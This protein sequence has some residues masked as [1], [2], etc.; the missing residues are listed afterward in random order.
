MDEHFIMANGDT[1]AAWTRIGE[2]EREFIRKEIRRCLNDP[3]YYLENYHIIRT[4]QEGLKTL[5]P[6]WDSQELF[7]EMVMKIRIAGKQCKIMILKARQLGL[8]TIC[9]GL[10]FWKTIFT[11]V[12]NALIV[13]TD[14]MK[15]DDQFEMSRL[16][17]DGLP[18]WM[19][20]ETRYDQKGRILNFD[21]RDDFLRKINPG[22]KSNIFVEAANKTT[23]VAR[24]KTIRACHMCLS[25]KNL[26][27]DWDGR[28]RSI[29]D[30]AVHDTVHD[31]QRGTNVAAV[32]AKPAWAVYEGAENGYRI[33]PW[34]SSA[35]PIEGTGNHRVLAGALPY[36]HGAKIA[37]NVGMRELR[38]L[39]TA[40]CLVVPVK[41]IHDHHPITLP[42]DPERV[43]G[44]NGH[45]GKVSEWQ[46]PLASRELGF[47]IGLYLAEGS[48]L[49]NKVAIS[50]DEDETALADRFAAAVGEKYGNPQRNGGSRTRIYYFHNTAMARWFERNLGACDNKRMPLWLW[51]C[52]REMLAGI[53]EGLILGDGHLHKYQNTTVFNSTRAALAVGIRE[54]VA[55]LGHG[56]GC[57]TE[58]PAGF[59]YGRNCQQQ[60]TV[61]FT[62][63][64]NRSIRTEYGWE[65]PTPS[66]ELA[67]R[68]WYYSP[69]KT[70]IYA[71]LRKVERVD[72]D[73]VYDI[74]VSIPGDHT[75]A[76]V[77]RLPS[78]LTHNSELATW[79]GGGETL[80]QQIFPSMN[81]DDTMAFMESTAEGRSGFWYRF[82]RDTWDGKTDWHPIFIPF[83]RVRKYSTPIPAGTTFVPTTDEEDYRHKIEEESGFRITDEVLNWRRMKI[84]THISLEGDEF[85]FMQEYP[86]NWIE[87]FQ[88]KGVC[89]F[90]KRLLYKMLATTTSPPR[91]IGEI[92]DDRDLRKPLVKLRS[93][94]QGEILHNP[95]TDDRF[96][97]WEKPEDSGMYYVGA[98]VAQGNDGG[99]FS[100]VQ[101]IRI[102]AGLE[103]DVQVAEWRGWVN[104][105]PFAYICAA[106]GRYYN[107]AEV[108]IEANNVGKVTNNELFRIIE[109]DNVYR[110]KH[111]DK[112]KNT[113]TNYI[114]WETNYKSREAIIAKMNEAIIERSITIRSEL[115]ID[116][117]MDFSYDEDGEG[118]AQGQSTKDDR[119]MAMMICRY[120]AHDSDYGKQ[121][122]ARPMTASAAG[123]EI[124]YVMDKWNRKLG[125]FNEQEAAMAVFRTHP[126]A[127]ITRKPRSEDFQNTMYS[128]I[129]HGNGV[130][131]RMFYDMGYEAE[132]ID[133][134]SVSAVHLAE[135]PPGE[136]D[137]DAWLSI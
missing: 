27:L 108:S 69:D 47:A 17:Y 133:H 19:R 104:P 61:T 120:C 111:I 115:L 2:T 13:A 79:E 44:T 60:W 97:V 101:V 86:S 16:A 31:G 76:H 91:W 29:A 90:N 77:F 51:S 36:G 132:R 10:V 83:Y 71:R 110:W 98:D 121:A 136:N 40:D 21:R 112:V 134:T 135:E 124:Y 72:L 116:E 123:N 70:E 64:S 129:H 30:I 106:I 96:W 4:E 103:P 53:V 12:C 125:E 54:A 33:T 85:G 114:G 15:A 52:G 62:D 45:G 119:V 126:G 1:A 41:A 38:E 109:Y 107:D 22:L 42:L 59:H 87:A 63:I 118:K 84:A 11:P 95:K 131:S 14:T 48:G 75:P 49:N 5:Y 74:E 3:R 88:G 58:R 7:Y 28:V 81:A 117:M 128:P 100:C 122:M 127:S 67:G 39:S 43:G 35:F 25:D 55:S 80:T 32:S 130:R 34:C 113:L 78:A 56:Y 65:N 8:S 37:S 50:L 105:T 66:A 102:G 6:F 46:I 18:W 99:D 57:I 89:A 73:T 94:A 93:V 137:P 20:P 92:N 26:V 68:H 24:G 23:G 9:E 82:W